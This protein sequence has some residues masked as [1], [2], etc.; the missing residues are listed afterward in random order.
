MRM[1]YKKVMIIGGA[2]LVVIVAGTVFFTY[3]SRSDAPAVATMR[4]FL[5]LPAL[6][7]DGERVRIE[8]VERNT[9]SIKRFYE[10]QDFASA[11]IR[12]D[13]ST[14]DG[15]KRLKLQERYM[16]NK[17]VEDIA[18]AHLAKTWGITISADAVS[19]AV[20]RPM[21]EMGTRDQ[22][23][24][25]L[26]RLYG[27]TL[28]DF[29]EK[30]VRPQ[31]LRERVMERYDQDNTVTQAMRDTMAQ[32]KKALDDGRPFDDVARQYSEGST[33]E[34]GGVI[35]WFA[36]GQTQDAIGKDI[37]SMKAGTYTDVI[38]TPL[39]LH[40][41]RVNEIAKEENKTL[42]HV[43]QIVVKKKSFAT[44]LGEHLRTLPVHV[45]LPG[46]A[47]DT[48]AA[49]IQFT[50]PDMIAFETKVRQDAE[51]MVQN[52]LQ[53]ITTNDDAVT[54]QNDQK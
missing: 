19:A 54:Q 50:D 11:G 40:I 46:Y 1:Q 27:W 41:V 52:L 34:E 14:D 20:D 42:V 49:L 45:Y 36:D 25:K 15:Q 37:F 35:G 12:V 21:E 23:V 47:W 44:F 31:L 16:L 39:G 32:A 30:V 38:E 6:S 28:A 7:V 17:L 48:D 43:S 53:N 22:V 33:A 24:E 9:A 26:D 51:Q 29:E 2:A 5:R 3:M 13:F 18:I 4:K 8:T 10:T